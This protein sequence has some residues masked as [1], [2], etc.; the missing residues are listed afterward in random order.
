M[1]T[2]VPSTAASLTHPYGNRVA[3]PPSS[4]T[5]YAQ[6]RE[7]E[8]SPA[9][10]TASTSPPGVQPRTTVAAAPPQ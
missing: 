1:A 4:G 6:R 8:L 5:A 7:N 10:L 3:G 9:A 2:R